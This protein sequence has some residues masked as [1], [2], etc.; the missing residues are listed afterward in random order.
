MIG[1]YHGAPTI[2][3]LLRLRHHHLRN[4]PCIAFIDVVTQ[5]HHQRTITHG[6]LKRL[7]AKD[8]APEAQRT[9]MT[10]Y[11]LRRIAGMYELAR[12][13][14]PKPK[15]KAILG[16][17]TR[18]AKLHRHF[19]PDARI[20]IKVGMHPLITKQKLRHLVA[21][22]LRSARLLPPMDIDWLL[23]R[24]RI[25]VQTGASVEDILCNVSQAADSHD[26]HNVRE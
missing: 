18:L 10:T 11:S 20:T 17:L 3:P 6:V 5:A 25:H 23:K 9:I 19:R 22:V 26:K 14:K 15:R 4:T 1:D 7:T 12:C 21:H 8:C 24:I 16:S 2:I 13:I